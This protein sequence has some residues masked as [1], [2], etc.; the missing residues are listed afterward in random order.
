VSVPAPHPEGDP[1]VAWLF[2]LRGSGIK[3]D[4]DTAEGFTR[5]LGNPQD[6]FRS[7]HVAGTNGKG[8]VA[9][10]LHG[11]ALA[12]GLRCGLNTSPH[13][14]RP[15]ERIRLG[16][17]DI[18]PDRFRATVARL[19][20]A[21]ARALAQGAVPRHP[22]FFEMM[23]AA[24]LVAFAEDRVDLA[25]VETGLGGRL[26]ATNVLRPELAVITSIARDHTR[27]LGR[28]LREIA[29]EKA[30]I[31]KPGVPFLVGPAP[32]RVEE[33]FR[34]V[35]R[36]RGARLHLTRDE[37]RL[38]FRRD[39]SFT[40]TTPRRRYPGLRVALAGRHQARNAALAVR[41]AELLAERGL[42]LD[43][44]EAIRRGLAGV[45]WPGRLQRVPGDPPVILDAAHNL[46]GIRSLVAA[47]RR[48]DRGGRAPVPRVLLFAA[49]GGRDGG[50]MVTLLAPLVREAVLTHPGVPQGNSPGELAAAVERRLRAAGLRL[51]LSVVA[52]PAQAL[53]AA[54]ARARALGGQVLVAGSL[55]LV[56]TVLGLLDLHPGP[57]GQ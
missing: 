35:A 17:D 20:E 43:D 27:T 44:P 30:G 32:R 46:A 14:V 2:S 57:P 4:L 39:G 13:L 48:E 18:S 56:G 38:A 21:A 25:V 52:D 50:R 8:S 55:Y 24:A 5:F 9:A 15:E 45:R 33:V 1:L 29:R 22:S 49:T 19:R 41:A 37:V 10:M 28:T 11:I 51:P 12:A 7:V 6:R 40:V 36:E 54:R 26:D 3:W 23:T 34:A 42:P 47:L 53:G 16:P 31:V